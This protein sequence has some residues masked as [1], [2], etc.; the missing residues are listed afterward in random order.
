MTLQQLRYFQ[1]LAKIQ[2]FTKASQA[3]FISQPSLSYAMSELE[4]ELNVCLFEKHGKKISLSAQGAVFLKYVES[5]L[6][7]LDEGIHKTRLLNPMSGKLNLGYISS[8]SSTFLP[9]VLTDFYKDESNNAITFNFVQNLNNALMESLK[10]GLID[11]AFCPN[12]YKDVS[13]IPI[14]QQEL[15]LIVPKDHPCAGKTEIDIHEV[16]NEPFI[17]TNRKSGLR[18]MV[19]GIF[20]EMKINPKI[21]FEAEECNVAIT[22]VALK[23]GLSIIPKIPTL[24]NADVSCI[25]LKNPEFNR[26]I[27]MAWMTSKNL[28]PVVKK[29]KEFIADRYSL[30]LETSV[31]YI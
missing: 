17:L 4:K 7:Q 5:A 8:L 31:P 9:G 10:E 22:F 11:L 27:F 28:P 19:G 12:P 3:L 2:H 13:Y 6:H 15:C 14:L 30:E 25:R 26:I 16:K 20:K 1:I 29:V 21:A 18:R 24:D 23:Y